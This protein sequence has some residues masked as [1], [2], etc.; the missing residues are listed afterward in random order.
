MQKTSRLKDLFELVERMLG[1]EAPDAN[2]ILTSNPFP[3]ITVP[4]NAYPEGLDSAPAVVRNDL[5]ACPKL[6]QEIQQQ[7]LHYYVAG[8]T[9]TWKKVQKK[10]IAT[11]LVIKYEPEKNRFYRSVFSATEGKEG[12]LGA[13]YHCPLE[14]N[15]AL[16]SFLSPVHQMTFPGT[17]TTMDGTPRSAGDIH[18]AVA[19]SNVAQFVNSCLDECGKQY[20]QPNCGREWSRDWTSLNSPKSLET[21]DEVSLG[22]RLLK[23]V[24]MYEELHYWYNWGKYDKTPEKEADLL[25]ALLHK[26]PSNTVRRTRP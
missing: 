23:Q 3:D 11:W 4:F 26:K 21:I 19:S 17:K 18:K 5:Q 1:D 20:R 12:D 13:N 14:K 10:L 6:M 25:A 24:G 7:V 15:A 8:K 22:L 2:T 9:L 16:T